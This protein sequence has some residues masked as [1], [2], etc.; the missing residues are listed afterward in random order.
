MDDMTQFVA[1]VAGIVARHVLP[2]AIYLDVLTQNLKA[3]QYAG[4]LLPLTTRDL[5]NK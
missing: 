3:V 4:M 1:N 2:M 5:M